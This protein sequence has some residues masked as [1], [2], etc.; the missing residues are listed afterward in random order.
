MVR[1][2]RSTTSDRN[3]DFTSL[4]RSEGEG[5][6]A[7]GER[8]ALQMQAADP[9]R[10]SHIV[11][12]GGADTLSFRLRVAQAHLRR[13]MLPSYW[14]EAMLVQLKGLTLEGA[15][16]VHVPLAQPGGLA[17]SP[18][19]N[20]IVSRPL[21]EFDDAARY[22]NIA[23]IALPVPQERMTARVEAF[24]RS[25]SSL[26]AL[27][28]VLRW[29]AFAWGVARTGNPLHENYGLP[30]ACMLETICAAEDFELT[31]GLESR[32]SC[33][34]AIWA[35][36][37]YWHDYFGKTGERK[38]P[39]GRFAVEHGYPILEPPETQPGATPPSR[40][41]ARKGATKKRKGR[42]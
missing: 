11:L 15:Q 24:R 36:A 26:D 21:V 10:W 35:S 31:P 7:W 28:H 1:Q 23:L 13:D 9:E 12:L 39:Y 32:A 5:N 19:E 42:S 3:P 41:S 20:G 4:P 17:F 27:E 29:L 22:P 8:A 33:P 6:L 25:R 38:V 34:E 2:A 30:S 40:T 37:I 18:H 16:A 14:S